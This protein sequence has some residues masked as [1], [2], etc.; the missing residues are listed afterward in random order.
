MRGQGGCGAGQGAAVGRGEQAQRELALERMGAGPVRGE[1]RHGTARGE[2]AQRG[3]EEA[4]RECGAVERAV[5]AL[6]LE[7][8]LEGGAVHLS[9]RV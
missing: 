2:V 3:L 1:P 9:P 5:A 4:R 6:E 8:G 7:G